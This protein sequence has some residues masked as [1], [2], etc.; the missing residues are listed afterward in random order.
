M[1]MNNVATRWATGLAIAGTMFFNS[2]CVETEEPTPKEKEEEV[3]KTDIFHFDEFVVT[4]VGGDDPVPYN[5]GFYDLERYPAEADSKRLY[6]NS[7]IGENNIITPDETLANIG[8]KPIDRRG[9][10]NVYELA[11]GSEIYVTDKNTQDTVAVFI[12][13]GKAI[14]TFAFESGRQRPE[15]EATED[16]HDVLQAGRFTSFRQY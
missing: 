11:K 16:L 3:K 14:I 8:S 15:E 7:T 6:M 5:T 4:T 1:R 10:V 9:A 2:G 12:A 13:N